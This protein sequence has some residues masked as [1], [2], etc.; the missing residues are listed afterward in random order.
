MQ[1][2]FSS[3][4]VN[5]SQG[6]GASGVT[7]GKSI[8]PLLNASLMQQMMRSTDDKKSSGQTK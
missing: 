6:S 1:A 7:N 2:Y 5:S 3:L 8:M 4:N